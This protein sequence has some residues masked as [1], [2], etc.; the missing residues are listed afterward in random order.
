MSKANK[1]YLVTGGSGFIGLRLS[2]AIQMS[3]ANLHLILRNKNNLI[4]CDQFISDYA[5]K[6]IDNQAFNGVETVF[7]LAGYAHDLSYSQNA[8]KYQEINVDLTMK[9]AKL[10]SSNNV[11]N[12][13]FISSVKAGGMAHIHKCLS[14]NDQGNP[15]DLYGKSKREAELRLLDFGKDNNLNISIVRPSLVYGPGMKGNLRS[16]IS[17]VKKGWFPPLPE[18]GNKKSMIHVDDLVR[19][20]LLVSKSSCS[21]GEIYIATDGKTYSSR[22]LYEIICE[23]SGKS[24][25]K[26]SVPE[27]L[28]NIAAFISPG[29]KLKVEKILGDECYSSRKLESLGFKPQKSLK[30]INETVF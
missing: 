27:V 11:R 30:D 2:N 1:T 19:A 3:G 4:K 25:P 29:V 6:N 18:T 21:N 10:A 20:I 14:E 22:K 7:H 23:Q 9:I 12:F 26:W 16:M 24:I 17:A 28:F 15:K 5:G 8:N 13:V